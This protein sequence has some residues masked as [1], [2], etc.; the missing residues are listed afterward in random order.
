MRSTTEDV[1][2][3]CAKTS[4]SCTAGLTAYVVSMPLGYVRVVRSDVASYPKLTVRPA[5]CRV[6]RRDAPS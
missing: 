2:G 3:R 6:V 5:H 1:A 4:V